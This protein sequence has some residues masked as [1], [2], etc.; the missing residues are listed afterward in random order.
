VPARLRT[1][2]SEEFA[3]V[4]ERLRA[5]NA[6]RADLKAAT[7]HLLALL[8]HRAPG[9]SVEVRVPPFAAVQCVSGARHTRGTPP[10]VVETDALT[11]VALATGELGWPEAVHA[12]RVRASGER[13][14]LSEWLPLV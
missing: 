12:G 14:D 2:S 8:E 7:K 10:A 6:D 11:W 9:R 1:L 4:R 5:G 3:D 13:S